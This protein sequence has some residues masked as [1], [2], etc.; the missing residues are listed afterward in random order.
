[1]R[2]CPTKTW[3]KTNFFAVILDAQNDFKYKNEMLDDSN[4]FILDDNRKRIYTLKRR[5]LSKEKDT[6]NYKCPF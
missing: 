2:V 3:R 5:I 1:M 4:M 6:S